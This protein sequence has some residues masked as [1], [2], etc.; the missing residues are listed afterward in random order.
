MKHGVLWRR[1]A[2]G[3]LLLGVILAGAALAQSGQIHQVTNPGVQARMATMNGANAAV[4]TLSDM[5]GGRMLFD[6]SRARAARKALLSNTGDIVS[7]FRHPH[8]DRLSHAR[9]EIWQRW[10]DFRNRAR[11]ARRAARALKTRSLPA[12]RKTLP[13]LISACLNCH[14]SYRAPM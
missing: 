2:I 7:V 1:P 12:L 11:S 8:S 9:P 6:R 3:L 13:E 4:T 14:Q 5:M 10:P